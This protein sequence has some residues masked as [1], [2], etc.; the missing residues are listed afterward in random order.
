MSYNTLVSPRFFMLLHLC[1][2]VIVCGH[3]L[4]CANQPRVS[5][6]AMFEPAEMRINPTFSRFKSF[7]ADDVPDG[8]EADLELRDR[9]GDPTKAAG[10]VY[11][12]L[13]RYQPTGSD[14][15]GE[16]VGRAI[17]FKLGTAAA[18][19]L[20]WQNVI[21]TY[22]FQLPWGDLD[23]RGS[24]VLSATYG[25]PPPAAG[26]AGAP[27]LFDRLVVAPRRDP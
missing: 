1:A 10:D 25:P 7:D 16:Q 20:H 6:S 8:I 13:F 22:R 14:V 23:P 17:V 4:G 15:R 27:R 3:L 18:Q 12:E 26:E 21:R 11:F 19:Q 9:F 5:R 2:S 24:Y